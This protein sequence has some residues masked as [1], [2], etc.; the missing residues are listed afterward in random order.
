MRRLQFGIIGCGQVVQELHLPAWARIGKAE[1]VAVCDSSPDALRA[2]TGRYPQVRRYADVDGFL[3]NGDDL[4]FVVLA[5]P[6]VSHPD[7]GERVLRRKKHLL[8][9]K[10]LALGLK[11]A[12]RLYEVAEA[13][14]VV[15]MPIHN[16][17]YRDV[18]V[19][20]LAYQASGDLGDVSYV[21]LR[22]RSG[23]L[24]DE[25]GLWRRNERLHRVLLFDF[26]YHFVDLA[27][28][29]A[30]PVLS[31]RF[32]EAE[33]DSMGLQYAAFRTLHEG[34]ARGLF[35]LMLDASCCRTELEVFGEKGAFALEFFPDGYRQ[36]PRRDN[37]LHRGVSDARRLFHYTLRSL[38]DRIPG[39]LATRAIPHARLFSDFLKVICQGGSAPI[40][41]QGVLQTIS[42]LDSV[43]ER[44]YGQEVAEDCGS[45]I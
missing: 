19:K 24:L 22:F 41:K 26:A 11:S 31:L 18:V 40:T 27:L 8:C 35:E 7:I 1:L 43:A 38:V 3:N 44:A 15:L 29:F 28:L 45:V 42:L 37:P 25:P 20:A 16:Y 32:I 17:R 36:L 9:E 2:V 12:E 10:P 4:D 33:T 21:S 30:G 14:D 5:T 6:G 39:R 23:S 34:G 13:E